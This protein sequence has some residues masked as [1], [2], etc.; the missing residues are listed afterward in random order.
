MGKTLFWIL[1]LGLQIYKFYQYRKIMIY[2]QN[3][4][5]RIK[6]LEVISVSKLTNKLGK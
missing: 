4:L 1:A 3:I 5:K 2:Y 6:D